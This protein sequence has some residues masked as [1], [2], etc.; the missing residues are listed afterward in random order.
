[1]DVKTVITVLTL[2]AISLGV[3]A[4]LGV[5]ATELDEPAPNTYETQGEEEAPPVDDD[6]K[7]PKAV[8]KE[9]EYEFGNMEL[10]ETGQHTFLL[11]NDG[12][13][14][15][16]IAKGASTCKC[17]V[18]DLPSNEIP[19]GES[20]EVFLEWTPKALTQS[21]SQR[22]RIWTNDPD[23]R[24]IDFRVNGRV[25]DMLATVPSGEVDAG[26]V[27]ED[28]GANARFRMYSSIADEFD[29]PPTI[30][31]DGDLLTFEIKPFEADDLEEL[32]AKSGYTTMID[33]S[34]DV[35]AGS[36]QETFTYHAKVNG[37]EYQE[38][39]SVKYN[40]R[41]P[42][43]IMP[44]RGTVFFEKWG[45]VDFQRFQASEGKTQEVT[46]FVDDPEDGSSIDVSVGEIEVPQIKV[47][48][49]PKPDFKLKGKQVF[50][51]IFEIPA[52][53]P[54][55]DFARK[56]APKIMINTTHPDVPEIE[57]HVE[58]HSR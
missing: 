16:K 44:R 53:A 14:V 6:E 11:K 33:V 41:G 40:R 39:V 5:S 50:R 57:L 45:L 25:A 1:M 43:R 13:D 58:A 36:G 46:L 32:S 12:E 37:K 21:F 54:P 56:T 18:S 17:T 31:Y 34:P 10:G 28:I 22:A 24:S 4:W 48:A 38:Q 55:L 23:Q 47:T 15:L 7:R 52:G 29:E 35:P 27:Q 8:A 20:I 2:I 19:P 42:L 3:T 9:T 26:N 51:L 49:E 30:E